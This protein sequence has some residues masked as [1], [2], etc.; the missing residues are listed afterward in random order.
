MLIPDHTF[1]KFWEIV[2]Q[3]RLFG[4]LGHKS[5]GK[6]LLV[7]DWQNWGEGGRQGVHA[8]PPPNFDR[9]VNPIS[10][11]VADYAHHINIH[12]PRFKG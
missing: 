9:P 5:I 2:Q 6:F 4:Q 12:L 11:K 8:S 7:K 3:P 10:T 1:I